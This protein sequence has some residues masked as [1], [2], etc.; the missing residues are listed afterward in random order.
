MVENKYPNGLEITIQS[1]R[2]IKYNLRFVD[3]N[4]KCKTFLQDCKICGMKDT[5]GK[6]G[7][8]EVGDKVKISHKL[9]NKYCLLY[10]NGT[11]SDFLTDIDIDIIVGNQLNQDNKVEN[12]KLPLGVMPKYIYEEQ[13]IQDICRALYEYSNYDTIKEKQI[14]LEWSEELVQRLKNL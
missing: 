4:I 14:M 1:L 7:N 2:N 3:C 8:I 10:D 12:I 5:N 13:R 9:N 6:V 11:C